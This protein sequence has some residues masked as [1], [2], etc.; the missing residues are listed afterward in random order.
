MGLV[1]KKP[2]MVKMQFLI[3]QQD[4]DQTEPESLKP[5]GKD[6]F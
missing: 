4:R 6:L 3:W 1:F 5:V 2:L